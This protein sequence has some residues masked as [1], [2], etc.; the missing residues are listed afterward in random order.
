MK[1]PVSLS[2]F[3]LLRLLL[4]SLT[5]SHCGYPRVL[6]VEWSNSENDRGWHG[7]PTNLTSKNAWY[8]LLFILPN[9]SN[10]PSQQTINFWFG[11]NVV[12]TIFEANAWKGVTADNF[13]VVL[14]F[15]KKTYKEQFLCYHLL[16]ILKPCYNYLCICASS[17]VHSEIL[18]KNNFFSFF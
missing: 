14:I 11:E 1:C 6:C 8:P 15:Q 17:R 2:V 13:P 12:Y 5:V 3:A 10:K 9:E 4:F 16:F 7:E 18:G